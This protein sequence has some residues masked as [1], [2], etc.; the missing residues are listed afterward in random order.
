MEQLSEAALAQIEQ[1][2]TTG[3]IVCPACGPHRKKKHERTLS[4]S[5]EA[6]STMYQCWHCSISGKI[7]RNHFSTNYTAQPV[8][9]KKVTKIPTQLTESTEKIL[10]FFASR[11]VHLESLDGLPPMVTGTPFYRRLE[12]QEESIGFVYGP[13]DC[14]EAIKW[15]PLNPKL[16]L[17]TQ[18][19]A[20]RSLWGLPEAGDTSEVMVIVEGECDVIACWSTGIKDVGCPYGAQQ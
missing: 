20:S 10:A 6:D 11:G 8:K 5:I 18:D 7:P 12:R 13:V 4:V 16:K 17:F 1:V 19:G 9:N 15:R 3:R 2:T 14:P